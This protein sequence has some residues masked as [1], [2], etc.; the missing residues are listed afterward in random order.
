M[1][2]A[3]GKQIRKN[4]VE[5]SLSVQ[6][7]PKFNELLKQN[8]QAIAKLKVPTICGELAVCKAQATAHW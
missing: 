3:N 8:L 4:S 7:L 6:V 2:K 5:M 1:K